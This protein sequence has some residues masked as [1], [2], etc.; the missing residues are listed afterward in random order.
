MKEF[1]DKPIFFLNLKK[2]VKTNF[3][4]YKKLGFYKIKVNKEHFLVDHQYF[5]SLSRKVY[6][7]KKQKN[8]HFYQITSLKIFLKTLRKFMI[9]KKCHVI[10]L[11]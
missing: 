6:F 10:S 1:I 3:N 11:N 7:F 9:F 2:S 4:F 8:F 5:E